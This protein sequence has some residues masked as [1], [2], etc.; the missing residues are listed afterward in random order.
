MLRPCQVPL[1]ACSLV[2]TA[3]VPVIDGAAVLVGG[4]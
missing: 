1:L 2:P 3:G 4:L